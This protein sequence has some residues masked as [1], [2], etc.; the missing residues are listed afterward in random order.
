MKKR[1]IIFVIIIVTCLGLAAFRI[2]GRYRADIY[3]QSIRIMDENWPVNFSHK[4]GITWDVRVES[5]LKQTPKQLVLLIAWGKKNMA[6][7]VIEHW[8]FE[9]SHDYL[10]FYP[11]DMNKSY[12]Q[13]E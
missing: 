5:I 8:M 7:V 12:V 13:Y 2:Y 1:I 10:E 4:L 11:I 6:Y 9:R 3:A